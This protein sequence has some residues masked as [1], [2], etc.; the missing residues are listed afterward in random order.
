MEEK[1]ILLLIKKKKKKNQTNKRN[2]NRKANK[3]WF[4][5]GEK[6][7]KIIMIQNNSTKFLCTY[8]CI[9]QIDHTA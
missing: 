6:S 4:P 9:F 1:Y 2:K 7:R 3:I 8:F 5:S